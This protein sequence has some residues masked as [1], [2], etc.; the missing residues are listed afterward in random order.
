MRRKVPLISMATGF[1]C[2]D[3]G[4]AHLTRRGEKRREDLRETNP[5]PRGWEEKRVYEEGN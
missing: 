2:R 4:R 5:G 1:Q 3:K